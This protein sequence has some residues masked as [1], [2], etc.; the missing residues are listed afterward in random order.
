MAILRGNPYANTL[1]GTAYGDSL[2]GYAGNDALYGYGGNDLLDGGSGNDLL[3]GGTGVD[4]ATY[5]SAGSRVLVDLTKTG[6]QNT[7]GSGID[8]LVS[9]ERLI[10]SAFD[11]SLIGNSSNNQ[12]NGG[13]GNDYLTGGA[14]AD[15]LTGGSG[16]DYFWY[17]ERDNGDVLTDFVS[18]VDHI[19]LQLAWGT[20]FHFIGSRAFSGHAGEGRFSNGLFQYDLDGDGHSDLSFTVIGQLVAT[21]I[22]AANPWAY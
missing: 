15:R 5:A 11:D 6:S 3:N 21:D 7:E 8:T 1:K 22:I 16:A 19:D 12:I 20:P 9:I 10:G 14:G 13:A 18:G 2:Y 17:G 4:T